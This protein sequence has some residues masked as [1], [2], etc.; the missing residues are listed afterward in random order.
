MALINGGKNTS[1]YASKPNLIFSRQISQRLF[2]ALVSC[3]CCHCYYVCPEIVLAL[4][5]VTVQIKLVLRV[6]DVVYLAL[7]TL[8]PSHTMFTMINGNE[9]LSL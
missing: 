5:D 3:Y 9:I 6:Q 7:W 1:I 2:V 8:W 4:L